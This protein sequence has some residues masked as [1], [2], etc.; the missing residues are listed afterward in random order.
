VQKAVHSDSEDCRTRQEKLQLPEVQEQKSDAA[1]RQLPNHHIEKELTA[2]PAPD[3]DLE[4]VKQAPRRH[5]RTNG[6]R[7]Q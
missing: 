2:A 3:D 1:D 6:L 5:G 4:P 7:L